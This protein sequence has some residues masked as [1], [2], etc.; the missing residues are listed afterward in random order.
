MTI[1][2]Q[3]QSPYYNQY[4]D[5]RQRMFNPNNP[6]HKDYVGLPMAWDNFWDFHDYCQKHLGPRPTSQ[7]KLARKRLERGFVPGNLAWMTQDQIGEHQRCS[8]RI[9][10][11]N[12]I[13]SGRKLCDHF[14]VCYETF[15]LRR[16]RTGETPLKIA[17]DLA[18][19]R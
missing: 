18:S 10:Y 12:H 14:G 15:N 8:L 9:R 6:N 19:A 17:K 4:R 3:K 13:W 1:T 11:K 5:I 16:K 2:K 7:H